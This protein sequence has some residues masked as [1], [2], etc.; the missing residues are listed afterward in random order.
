[1]TGSPLSLSAV[2]IK[3]VINSLANIGKSDLKASNEARKMYTKTTMGIG[4]SIALFLP[5][6][7]LKCVCVCV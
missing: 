4:G 6:R 5:L 2:S 7:C 3:A 1:M